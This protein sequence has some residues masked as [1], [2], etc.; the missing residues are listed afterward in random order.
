MKV[1]SMETEKKCGCWAVLK[2]GVRGACKPSASRDSANTIP[3]PSLLYD[4]GTYTT[5]HSK[6]FFSTLENSS[7]SL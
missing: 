7:S 2:R 6:Q 4:A 1:V 5:Q 3:R